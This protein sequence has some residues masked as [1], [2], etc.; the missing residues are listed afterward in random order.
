MK[1]L[2]TRVEKIRCLA[3]KLGL[4][5]FSPPRI[6]TREELAE[7]QRRNYEHEYGLISDLG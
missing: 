5:V 7:E 4:F 6:L 3:E 2:L 1:R